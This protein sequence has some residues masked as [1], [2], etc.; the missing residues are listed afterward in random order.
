MTVEFSTKPFQWY[1]FPPSTAFGKVLPKSKIY[2]KASPSAKVKELFVKQVDQIIWQHK[3]APETLHISATETVPE[4]QVFRLLL[5]TPDVDFQVLSCI[6]KAI[7]FPLFFELCFED[8]FQVVAAYKRPSLTDNSKCSIS[9]YFCS[10]WQPA[11]QQCLP[12]PVVLDLAVLY[13]HLLAGLV[14]LPSRADENTDDWILRT[15][16]LIKLNRNIKRLQNKL[17]NEKQFNRKVEL[18]NQLKQLQ[19]QQKLL[20]Q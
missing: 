15:E 7:P 18:H 20:L 1:V 17:L 19:T 10:N 8:R 4:I 12:L 11:Q 16:Q 3:L 9:E 2:E 5:K 13:K 14:Y 6:D